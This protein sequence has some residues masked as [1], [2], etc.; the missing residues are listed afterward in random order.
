MEKELRCYGDRPLPKVCYRCQ[1]KLI[2]VSKFSYYDEQTGEP[3][4]NT[5]LTCPI[6]LPDLRGHSV[7][8]FDRFGNEIIHFY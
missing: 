7:S 5:I 2:R 6:F 1:R 4:Y 8:E 3:Q